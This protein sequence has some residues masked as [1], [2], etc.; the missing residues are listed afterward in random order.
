MFE[1]LTNRLNQ[2]FDQLRRRGK[3]SEADVDVGHAR[4]APGPA[5]SG[6]ALQRGQDIRRACAR[7]RCWR[8]GFEGAESRSA[9]HQ[10]RQ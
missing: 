2:V 8:G 6:C 9:G 4:S 1:S 7:T 3:L 5:R 10:D